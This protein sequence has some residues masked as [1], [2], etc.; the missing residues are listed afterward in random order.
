MLGGL[1]LAAAVVIFVARWRW[2]RTLSA[3]AREEINSEN[4]IALE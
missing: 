2:Q 1:V 4:Q 3:R